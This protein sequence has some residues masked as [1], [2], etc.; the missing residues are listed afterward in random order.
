M[1]TDIRETA[2]NYLS[3]R[4]YTR[5]ELQIKLIHKGYPS[6]SVDDEL[7]RLESKGY[8]SDWRFVE[9]YIASRQRRGFGP[10]HIKQG[11]SRLQAYPDAIE[12]GFAECGI[13][14]DQVLQ[15]VWQ[16]K[17]GLRPNGS[18]MYAKQTRFLL[19]RG[20]SPQSIRDFLKYNNKDTM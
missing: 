4:E 13:D 16:R 18:S 7:E 2:L 3:R 5:H 15:Q 10:A 6:Q 12:A 8:L 17:F 19:Q 11:L 1:S 20:F 14:W 9:S